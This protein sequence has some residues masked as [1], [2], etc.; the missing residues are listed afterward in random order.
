M[1]DQKIKTP[2]MFKLVYCLA[3]ITLGLSG[4]FVLLDTGSSNA[5]S[6]QTSP[7][8]QLN[9]VTHTTGLNDPVV[10]THAGDDRLFVVEQAGVIKI[11]QSNGTAVITPFLDITSRVDSSSS[12]EGLLGLTFHPDYAS[13][14][15]FYLNYI[16]TTSGVRRT[17][18]SRFEVSNNPNVTNP[19]SEE[20]LLTITQPAPNHN[21]GDIHFGPDGYLYIPLG[22]G[23]GSGDPNDNAQDLGILLGKVVRIDVDAVFGS[24]SDCKGTGTGNYT[25]P[26][27]NPLTD[28][29]GACDEIWAAGLRNPWRSSFDR[30]T[31]GFYIGDV[32]QNAWEEIDFQPANSIGGEN[33]GWDCNEG[34][35]IYSGPPDSPSPD[36]GSVTS[37]TNPIFE[38]K[39][40]ASPCTSV[41]GGYIYRGS[42][43][44]AMYGRYL[45]TDYCQGVF[46]DLAPDG[47]GWQVTTHTN[48]SAFGFSTFG[49]DANG[50]LY[51]ANISNDTIYRLTA[52]SL[53]LDEILFLPII[54]KN[55]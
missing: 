6:I 15:F 11:L 16:N 26:I 2:S 37:F 18:I 34:N 44:P 22:D 27:T 19:N 4:T 12:E 8:I 32:G 55:S 25:I 35:H 20:I 28:V 23:G 47:G 50:E 10:I 48:L 46:W 54:L 41:T 43:Y 17:R 9:L 38:Y 21:A 42:Q 45:L 5:V 1:I 14:G 53:N 36:C 52:N 40:F 51:V 49:E 29:I 24:P 30:L 39:H 3:V 31:G 33:Y 7:V 13:N